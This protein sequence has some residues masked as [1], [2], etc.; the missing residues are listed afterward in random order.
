MRPDTIIIVV[1]FNNID[2]SAGIY[3]PLKSAGTTL[4][5]IKQWILDRIELRRSIPVKDPDTGE[6]LFLI[7]ENLLAVR[8]TT[9]DK[10]EQAIQEAERFAQ[11][12]HATR[13]MGEE[14]FGDIDL[15]DEETPDSMAGVSS[16]IEPVPTVDE[17]D[18]FAPSWG[19][20]PDAPK[21]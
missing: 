16:T 4:L 8:A 20:A 9:V 1:T 2:S 5:E 6:Q 21:T 14:S 17:D 13:E 7:T 18:D 19:A 12:A 11:S 10:L 3:L 15:S